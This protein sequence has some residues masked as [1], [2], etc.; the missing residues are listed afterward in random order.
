MFSITMPTY[1]QNQEK[2]KSIF[3]NPQR[4]SKKE[5]T[6]KKVRFLEDCEFKNKMKYSILIFLVILVII[7][8]ILYFSLKDKLNSEA[9]KTYIRQILDY[10]SLVT[11]K[12]KM[13]IYK[14]DK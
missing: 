10:I 13:L 12:I 11:M 7:S 6:I 3:K 5:K 1:P 9:N 4:N 8:A 2:P 14:P